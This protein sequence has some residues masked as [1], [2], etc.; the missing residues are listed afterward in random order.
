[1][2]SNNSASR[3]G[4]VYLYKRSGSAWE[5]EAYFK[6]VNLDGHDNFGGAVAVSG[7]TL[8]VGAPTEDSNQTTISNGTT[9][10]ANNLASDAG[11]V[12]VYRNLGRIA[13][14]DV[15]VLSIASNSIVFEWGANL[16]TAD[17]VLVAPVALGN[18]TPSAGCTGGTL[19]AVGVTSY[20]YSGLSPGSKYGFRFCGW[21]GSTA[22][23]GT[24]IWAETLGLP[25]VN[26]SGLKPSLTGTCDP[27]AVLHSATTTSGK[28]TSVSCTGTGKLNLQLSLPAGSSSF[29]V[30]FTSIFANGTGSSSQSQVTRT[31]F[32]CPA[33]Y[34]GVPGSGVTGLGSASASSGHSSWWLNV[35]SDFC[36]MKYPAKNNNSS[37]FAT[38]TAYGLP[39]VS[40]QRGINENTT[41]SAFK[42]CNDAG[43][44]YRLI[45]NT[46]WQTI[47]RNA[48]KVAENWS[49]AAVGS[50]MM[51][52]GHLD[53]TPAMILENSTDDNPFFGTGNNVNQAPGSGWEQMRTR[54]LSN[55]ETVWDMGGN[56]SQW[57]SD[58]ST[59]LGL[60][61]SIS[62]VKQ[63]SDRIPFPMTGPSAFL[64]RLIL[65]P[66]GD[67]DNSHG[68]GVV[69]SMASDGILRGGHYIVH[70]ELNRDD[71]NEW[72]LWLSLCLS[73]PINRVWV[74]KHMPKTSDYCFPA[75]LRAAMYSLRINFCRELKRSLRSKADAALNCLNHSDALNLF[76]N[77]G[78][79]RNLSDSM[80]HLN[81]PQATSVPLAGNSFNTT[82][83][84]SVQLQL[85]LV[86]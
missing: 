55:G 72:I 69:Y 33:G 66:L 74:T 38:S 48:E 85:G 64:N 44:G 70:G 9:A 77:C 54:L 24:T 30:G 56:V 46:Q 7:D 63:F 22:S 5:Q 20:T 47:A 21:N 49:G 25:G 50:G 1:M 4:A 78:S 41:P 57:V 71:G 35:D 61:P 31:P 28:V 10:S 29:V 84:T 45:S 65:G 34:V 39:W 26:V 37:T 43:P 53:G 67:F 52:R 80:F 3:S 76:E 75:A 19:L 36:V 17:R 2:T 42:A 40:L 15:R 8:A 62:S 27:S 59:S 86:Q 18:S 13:D 12:Y 14:P 81:P 60:S 51:A 79:G 23:D 58:N 11:A 73:A 6:A 83:V 82:H 32:V 16:G 68:L